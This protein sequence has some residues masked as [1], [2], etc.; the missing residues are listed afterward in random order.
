M[1]N[2]TF[3]ARQLRMLMAEREV[4]TIRQLAELSGIHENSLYGITSGKSQ[5]GTETLGR[6]S[7][8]LDCLVDDFF[9]FS[10]A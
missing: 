7:A 8:A 3:S 10:E 1:T 5:P 9:A 4:A 2:K 6:L